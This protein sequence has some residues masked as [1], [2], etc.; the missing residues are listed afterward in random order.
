MKLRVNSFYYVNKFVAAV[1]PNW[2][3]KF[4]EEFVPKYILFLVFSNGETFVTSIIGV[5]LIS[6]ES[7]TEIGLARISFYL[8]ASVFYI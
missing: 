3:V 5:F 6:C 1:N 7:S 8:E 4:F 2:V